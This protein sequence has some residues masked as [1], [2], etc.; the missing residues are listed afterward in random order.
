MARVS[1]V[2]LKDREG[3]VEATALARGPDKELLPPGKW[4]VRMPDADPI[5]MSVEEMP[6]HWRE[7]IRQWGQ[8]GKSLRP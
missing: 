1:F 4:N 3:N 6:D 2:Q 7:Q 8:F 5:V